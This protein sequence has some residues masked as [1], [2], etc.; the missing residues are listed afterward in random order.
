M[1]ALF[2]FLFSILGFPGGLNVVYALASGD[3]ALI[4]HRIELP[5]YF[6][7]FIILGL[8][9]IAWGVLKIFRHVDH[10]R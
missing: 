2:S 8:M 10:D 6:L 1:I 3:E 4:V 9:A 5:T 7:L